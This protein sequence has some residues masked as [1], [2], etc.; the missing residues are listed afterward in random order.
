V[1]TESLFVAELTDPPPS[2][3]N[4]PRVQSAAPRGLHNSA[5]S[6]Y[7][8][9]TPRGS[10]WIAGSAVLASLGL[11]FGIAHLLTAPPS[12]SLGAS[13]DSWVGV[14][15]LA[16]I[17]HAA[18]AEAGD[19][20]CPGGM[21]RVNAELC[22]DRFEAALLPVREED[23]THD[24]ETGALQLWP[25]NMPVKG[26][27]MR[28][29][30]L[31][32]VTPQAYV[33]GEEAKA[34]CSAAGKRLC[35]RREWRS[36]CRGA[37]DS[38]FPYGNERQAQTCNDHGRN[39]LSVVFRGAESSVYGSWEKLNDP[40]LNLV[41]ATV[42]LT[43]AHEGCRGA[44]E[45]YDMVGNLHEW[46]DEPFGTFLGGYFQDTHQNGDGCGYT[47]DRH[48]MSYHDYSTGFRCCADP[49]DDT[50]TGE[51]DQVQDAPK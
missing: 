38:T 36:A 43:G 6:H 12:R 50:P 41:D 49:S 24:E 17:G 19:P 46:I 47:T 44:L 28:A 4:R 2:V 31:R 14:P 34:A 39:P 20:G 8:P 21:A 26:R 29:L 13:D 45:I 23:Q 15:A 7:R 32:G 10:V 11:A 40:R 30:S 16:R 48:V 1:R 25:A 37:A 5:P 42:A 35:A 51:A 33:S 27:P 9:R 18:N 3:A 22:I